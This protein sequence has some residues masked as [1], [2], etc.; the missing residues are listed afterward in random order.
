VYLFI[1]QDAWYAYPFLLT[2]STWSVK[3]ILSFLA[4]DATAGTLWSL[5]GIAFFLALIALSAVAYERK[6]LTLGG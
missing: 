5:G 3:A 6:Q 2:P 4:G 1:P